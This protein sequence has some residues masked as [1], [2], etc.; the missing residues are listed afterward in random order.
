MQKNI[1][2]LLIPNYVY[3]EIPKQETTL[4]CSPLNPHRQQIWNQILNKTNEIADELQDTFY[5]DLF[6]N[7]ENIFNRKQ[8]NS[9]RENFFKKLKTI[10][11]K[12]NMNF[13]FNSEKQQ[14]KQS[15]TNTKSLA[16]LAQEILDE[17]IH[18]ES[19]THNEIELTNGNII[20]VNS[21]IGLN[22][23]KLGLACIQL[24]L[25]IVDGPVVVEQSQFYQVLFLESFSKLF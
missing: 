18:L 22:D 3:S 13:K 23:C 20:K 5:K 6:T 4:T 2:F 11:G 12:N 1:I 10:G 16:I 9:N 7:Q 14:S 21:K 24:V 25:S 17:T 19:D 15:K 8:R